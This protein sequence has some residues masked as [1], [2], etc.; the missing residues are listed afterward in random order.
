MTEETLIS[1]AAI[2]TSPFHPSSREGMSCFEQGHNVPFACRRVFYIAVDSDPIDRGGHANSCDEL[3][4]AV[5][6]AVRVAFDNGVERGVVRLAA[7]DRALWLRA[8][9]LIDLRDFAAGTVLMVFAS[10][11]FAETRH[12]DRPQP[13]LIPELAE[14]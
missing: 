4:V 6:G 3:I 2:L 1:G 10:Q 14:T 13:Q 11:P 12:F 8:G 9:L 7:P 5:S